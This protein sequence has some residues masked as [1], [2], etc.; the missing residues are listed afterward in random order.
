MKIIKIH[1]I[2]FGKIQNVTYNLKEINQIIANNGHGKTSLAT[3]IECMFF[4]MNSSSKE[5]H[6]KY[7][8]WNKSLCGGYLIFETN[9]KIYKI[10]RTFGAKKSDEIS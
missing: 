7:L 3:F 9:Q 10:E 2:G 4:G 1:I 6:R 5:N 8:P